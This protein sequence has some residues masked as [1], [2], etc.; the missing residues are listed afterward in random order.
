METRSQNKKDI[1]KICYNALITKL[2]TMTPLII[3]N[4]ISSVIIVIVLSLYSNKS[5]A[6]D[7]IGSVQVNKD[8]CWDEGYVDWLDSPGACQ[9]RCSL[10]P[11]CNSWA[12]SHS[13]SYRC[14]L[15]SWTEPRIDVS[16][17]TETP[18][19]TWGMRG[20]DDA[21]TLLNSGIDSAAMICSGSLSPNDALIVAEDL[22]LIVKKYADGDFIADNAFNNN[23]V[24]AATQAAAIVSEADGANCR[25]N[26][27]GPNFTC[28]YGSIVIH[29]LRALLLHLDSNAARAF[30]RKFNKVRRKLFHRYRIFL[31]DNGWM[32]KYTQNKIA[33]FYSQLPIHMFT[34]G[35]LYDA[36]FATQTV[37]D[38]WKCDGEDPGFYHTTNRGFNVFQTQVGKQYE[39]A[40]PGDTPDIPSSLDLQLTVT[41]HEVAHQFDRIVSNR[42][43]QGDYRLSD[44]KAMLKS[45]SSGSD[46]NWLRSQ[47]GDSYF[48]SAPQEIIASQIGNQYLGSTSSQLRLA[49]Y[50]LTKSDNWTAP[51]Y[52]TVTDGLATLTRENKSCES[53]TKNLGTFSTA[54]ECA[55]E[56]I[57]DAS[58]SYEI[59]Y[60]S[61]YPSWGCRCCTAFED[62]TCPSEESLYTSHNLWDIYQYKNS[63]NGATCE[64]T[65]LPL[66]WFLFNVDLLTPVGSNIAT[67]YENEQNGV[68]T[69][70]QIIVTR[71]SSSRITALDIPYCGLVTFGYDNTGIVN[72]VSDNAACSFSCQDDLDWKLVLPNGR[73]KSCTWIAKRP[74]KRCKKI[75]RGDGR[76]AS[77]VCLASCGNCKI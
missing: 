70:A 5:Y 2:N 23:L 57:N 21:V 29:Q 41:R 16:C 28:N 15:C 30:P 35:I 3:H 47:V 22:N 67:F 50:R 62:L 4:R 12:Y 33:K 68:V 54:Q 65:G 39:Q 24:D 73:K 34:E 49:S 69:R 20:D 1:K 71:D 53:Q 14:H 58:C 75:S 56:A 8:S 46:D 45:A 11:N 43:N 59:M 27:S 74:S 38:A 66:S 42:D 55:A 61:A 63:A 7:V 13:G 10:K 51:T 44:M 18:C 76:R 40:F 36:A 32:T 72:T 26:Y 60:S 6:R 37:R 17:S 52:S 77:E 25:N 64:N 19:K 48:Q 31:A 9:L